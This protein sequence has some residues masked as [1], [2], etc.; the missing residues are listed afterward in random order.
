MK[1]TVV[2]ISIADEY[3]AVTMCTEQSND[4]IGTDSI[5]VTHAPVTPSA[6]VLLRLLT[7]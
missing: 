4:T 2:L 5:Y 1:K 6:T 3:I 7:Q